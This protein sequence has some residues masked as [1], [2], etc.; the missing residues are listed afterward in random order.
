MHT[1]ACETRKPGLTKYAVDANLFRL[2]FTNPEKNSQ[3]LDAFWTKN[4]TKKNVTFFFKNVSIFQQ[5]MSI[6]FP[7]CSNSHKDAES[8]ESKDK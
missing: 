5:K 7:K 6:I 3:S 8:A 2:G 4:P 1:H